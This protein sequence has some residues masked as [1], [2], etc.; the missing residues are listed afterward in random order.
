M[1]LS[2]EKKRHSLLKEGFPQKV[3]SP[4]NLI[5]PIIHATWAWAARWC[6][7]T[8]RCH[9]RRQLQ[10]QLLPV[11]ADWTQAHVKHRGTGNEE[12]AQPTT[13]RN[14]SKLVGIANRKQGSWVWLHR[15]FTLRISI[16]KGKKE[17]KKNWYEVHLWSLHTFWVYVTPRKKLPSWEGQKKSPFH[18]VLQLLM[19]W[20]KILPIESTMCACLFCNSP[21]EI[22]FLEGEKPLLPSP[23]KLQ[24][25]APDTLSVTRV[26]IMVSSIG[27]QGSVPTSLLEEEKDTHHHGTDRRRCF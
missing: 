20:R 23:S 18:V 12:H 17:R 9:N 24:S 1:S 21:F 4:Y 26:R 14:S 22:L 6:S 27:Q 8:S 10:A 13:S 5:L 19:Y 15:C 2:R 16:E 3:H 11:K 25:S 7:P